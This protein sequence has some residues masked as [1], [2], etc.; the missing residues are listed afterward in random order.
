MQ[1]EHTYPLI[2]IL[3]FGHLSARAVREVSHFSYNVLVRRQVV[4]S[5]CAP[6]DL[7]S[8][9]SKYSMWAEQNLWKISFPQALFLLTVQVFHSTS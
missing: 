7:A 9:S 8:S 2:A 1:D 5:R 4:C 3:F 6:R